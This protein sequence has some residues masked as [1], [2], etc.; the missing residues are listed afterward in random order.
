[1]SR[2]G[3][4]AGEGNSSL[5]GAEGARIFWLR[6]LAALYLRLVIMGSYPQPVIEHVS[7]DPYSTLK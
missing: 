5:G 2:A 7:M 4:S 6:P 3:G 1:M